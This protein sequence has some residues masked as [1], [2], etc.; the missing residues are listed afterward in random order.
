MGLFVCATG[1]EGFQAPFPP[2]GVE[3]VAD[4]VELI[5]GEPAG[6]H[7]EL[8]GQFRGQL[9]DHRVDVGGGHDEDLLV[10]GGTEDHAADHRP[11]RFQVAN[12][13]VQVPDR[14]TVSP[15]AGWRPA[16]RLRPIRRRLPIRDLRR[17]CLDLD[18]LVAPGPDHRDKA[19][20]AVRCRVGANCPNVD[21]EQ[22]DGPIRLPTGRFE[23]QIIDA[24]QIQPIAARVSHEPTPGTDSIPCLEHQVPSRHESM[25]SH[26]LSSERPELPI[27][28]TSNA[29]GECPQLPLRV[30]VCRK[31][32]VPTMRFEG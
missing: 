18:A 10:R 28:R 29:R 12:V 17:L 1:A 11:G 16:R 8:I 26:K 21:P 5:A 4:V 15:A 2:I 13:E 27:S 25:V 30:R 22:P 3:N 24:G 20:R 14:H 6:Y 19:R 32:D 31:S 9:P 23:Q 7:A